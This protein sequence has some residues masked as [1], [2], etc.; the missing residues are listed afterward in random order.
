MILR[1]INVHLLLL[2]LLLLEVVVEEREK[3]KD[4]HEDQDKLGP[5]R[6]LT[7][8]KSAPTMAA[9]MRDAVDKS[10]STSESSKSTSS[11]PAAAA[12]VHK[13]A[14]ATPLSLLVKTSPPPAVKAEGLYRA[15]LPGQ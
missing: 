14:S 6:P 8:S 15:K 7:L 3:E 1:Y 13:S 5:L 4:Q 10:S 9:V 11:E 12:G 2:L